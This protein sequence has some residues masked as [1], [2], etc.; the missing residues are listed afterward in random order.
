M[1]V[2]YKVCILL[3]VLLLVYLSTLVLIRTIADNIK[4]RKLNIHTKGFRSWE[5]GSLY[6][7]AEST[8]YL[9]LES[10]V[11]KYKF[12]DKDSLVDFGAG[13]GR[14][15]IFIHHRCGI[16]VTGVELN[17]LTYEDAVDNVNSYLDKYG[18][19]TGIKIEKEYAE[20]YKIKNDENKFFFFNPFN[21]VI[22]K[23]VVENILE[24]A[25]EHGKEIDIIL[26]YPIDEYVDFLKDTPLK[27]YKNIKTH[28]AIFPSE[29]F[30]IYKFIP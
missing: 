8:P 26:Y 22:F 30:R 18:I 6:N 17:E 12:T 23:E 27:L 16:P 7:R 19:N 25:K 13:K 3:G 15:S 2:V 1:I 21:V 10:L 4:D 14:V 5:K 28:G 9:A 11:Q 24:N 20:K 29:H